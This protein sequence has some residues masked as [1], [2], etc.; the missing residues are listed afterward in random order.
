MYLYYCCAK[1]Y[2]TQ[3]LVAKVALIHRGK[4]EGVKTRCFVAMLINPQTK[5]L[6]LIDYGGAPLVRAVGAE[7]A[8]A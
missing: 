6:L 7:S 1:F 2:F 4:Q 8:K 3:R 5:R